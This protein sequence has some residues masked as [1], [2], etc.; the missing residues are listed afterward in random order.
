MAEE[1]GDANDFSIARCAVVGMAVCSL[2]ANNAAEVRRYVGELQEM[3]AESRSYAER[4]II[5]GLMASLCVLERKFELAMQV[6]RVL[7]TCVNIVNIYL[8]AGR[9]IVCLRQLPYEP[10]HPSL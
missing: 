1:A 10:S 8:L 2:R 7:Q 4:A 5:S 3:G 6:R 9:F